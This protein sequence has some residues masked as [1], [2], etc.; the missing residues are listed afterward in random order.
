MVWLCYIVRC[1][2]DSLY[3]GITNNLEK[4]IK[5][6]NDGNGAKYT[7]SRRPV[8]LVFHL[9]CGTKSQA[10]Q[11]EYEIK[12]MTKMEK[13]KL[14]NKRVYKIWRQGFER[15]TYGGPIHFYGEVEASSFQE[16]CNIFFKNNFDYDAIKLTLWNCRLFDNEEDAK[17]FIAN[18]KKSV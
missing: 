8:V 5:K 11:K 12:R 3:T 10:A 6:H 9:N 7:R 16:A 1:A 15:E 4:R 14:I 17:K 18:L 2:D 13:E